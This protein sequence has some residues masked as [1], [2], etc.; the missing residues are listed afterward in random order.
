M[1]LETTLILFKPDAVKKN[2]VGTVLARF[3][4]AGFTIRGIKMME[5]S[6]ELLAEQLT[7]PVRW[8]QSMQWAVA[9]GMTEYMEVGPGRV[10]FQQQQKGERCGEVQGLSNKK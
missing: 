8:S 3:Q 1:A 4:D 9:Q 7:S 10:L 2:L 5:L 6:D